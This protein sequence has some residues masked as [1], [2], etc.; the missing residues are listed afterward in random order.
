MLGVHAGLSD[1][2]LVSRLAEACNEL[3]LDVI[4]MGNILGFLMDARDR[5]MLPAGFLGP[6]VDLRWGDW[7]GMLALIEQTGARRGVGDL[8][9]QGLEAT[10]RAAGH[11]AEAIAF[12]AKGLEFAGWNPKGEPAMSVAYATSSRGAC[13]L[14]GEH[15]G[16]QDRQALLDSVG[17][18]YFVRRMTDYDILARLASAVVGRAYTEADLMTVGERVVNLERCFN[19]RE[20]FTAADDRRLPAALGREA[21]TGVAQGFS[22]AWFEHALAACYASRGWD[23]DSGLPGRARLE[24]LGLGFVLPDLEAP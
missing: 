2:R 15:P 11:G 17:G 19:A 21:L 8:L 10:A 5:G 9:S 4:S 7:R 12:H 3:G 6:G 24:R 22:D 23:R 16:G 18:C 13:H 20:G 14:F 1:E